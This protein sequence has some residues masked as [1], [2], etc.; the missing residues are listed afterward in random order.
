[1]SRRSVRH[2]P[3]AGSRRGFT[4]VELIV[5]I[6]IIALLGSIL[7]PTIVYALRQARKTASTVQLQMIETALE[8]YRGD[9]NDYPRFTAGTGRPS[10]LN[11]QTD[12]GARLLA[13]ALLGPAPQTAAG[14]DA[15]TTTSARQTNQDLFHD[16]HNGFGTKPSRQVARQ[17]GSGG[18]YFPGKVSGPYLDVDEWTLGIYAGGGDIEDG[19]RPISGADDLAQHPEVQILS[20]NGSPILYYPANPLAVNLAAT[21]ADENAAG[22][23]G[24]PFASGGLVSF[25]PEAARS[26][27]RFN[28]FDNAFHLPPA[29]ANADGIEDADPDNTGELRYGLL[30]ALLGDNNDADGDDENRSVQF[31]GAIGEG[32]V[33]TQ[34]TRFLLITGD[35]DGRFSRNSVTNFQPAAPPAPFNGGLD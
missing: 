5:V 15:D 21:F 24:G 32:E 20:G 23:P 26:S 9:H 10:A 13:R 30:N 6:G 16:G 12:R 22:I 1:M 19:L 33:A 27:G 3:P 29:I 34:E 4:L 17:S 18:F 25:D 8:G 28:S 2:H 35:T 31:D 14:A 11:E 7:L